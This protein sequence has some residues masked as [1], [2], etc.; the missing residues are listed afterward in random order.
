MTGVARLLV[1]AIA[2]LML[3]LG[4]AGAGRAEAPIG[5]AVKAIASVSASRDVD[6]RRLA[7]N[8][9]VY[10][11]ELVQTGDASYAGLSFGD[12]TS[13]ALGPNAEVLM[14]EFVYNGKG[15]AGQMVVTVAKG[16]VRFV[17]GQMSQNSYTVRTPTATIGIRGT[18]FVVLVLANG[19]TWL[20]VQQGQATIQNLVGQI[21]QL[22]IAGQASS[23][24]P[25]APGGTPPLPTIPAGPPQL[26]LAQLSGLLAAQPQPAEPDGAPQ[27][28]GV[29]AA[30][31][32]AVGAVSAVNMS[33]MLA[34]LQQ[35][36][37]T[38]VAAD[39]GAAGTGL[40]PYYL[41]LGAGAVLAAALVLFV[42]QDD[43]N[44]TSTTSTGE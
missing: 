39:S 16:A 42:I 14:D 23:V 20:L 25:P 44:S 31:A 2:A 7:R 12:G 26:L 24:A 19:Q 38:G 3:A 40:Q 35:G 27:V 21:A 1:I 34:Q 8:D 33:Q 30:V 15:G 18:I 36:Q 37:S 43:S 10:R 6:R 5:E 4:L 11:N 41:S 32:S 22:D 29:V 13:L 28:P 9:P 17:S